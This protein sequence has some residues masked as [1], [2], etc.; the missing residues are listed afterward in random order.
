V[1][2]L[3]GLATGPVT[4]VYRSYNPRGDDYGLGESHPGALT[5]KFGRP[6]R[7][8]E[9][10]VVRG[11]ADAVESPGIAEADLERAHAEVAA[12]YRDF[13]KQDEAYARRTS[14]SFPLGA[15]GDPRRTRQRVELIAAAPW[16]REPA[17][18]SRTLRTAPSVPAFER[19]PARHG[20][21]RST[22]AV[23]AALVAVIAVISVVLSGALNGKSTP[24]ASTPAS[25]L[26]E[27]CRDLTDGRPGDAYGYMSEPLRSTVSQES[28]T[29]EVLSTAK[30]ANTCSYTLDVASAATAQG[31]VTITV[32][33][34]PPAT[35]RVTLAPEPDSSW[36]ITALN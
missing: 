3:R 8:A 28:F 24:Q 13:W 22:L 2:E 30:R 35:W 7:I 20:V 11:T 4:V 27:F 5:D 29:G 19:A 17:A 34:A 32:D 33:A 9:G 6:V 18:D 23:A 26:A 21:R 25:V 16:R 31:S 10:F 15:N 12:A 36:L 14:D 1:R